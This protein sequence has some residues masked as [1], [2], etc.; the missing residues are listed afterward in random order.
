TVDGGRWTVDGGRWT[1]D[2]KNGAQK[3]GITNHSQIFFVLVNE[4]L[5]LNNHPLC[6]NANL[7]RFYC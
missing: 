2:G 5:I 4:T 1:V 3:S 7:K 6:L